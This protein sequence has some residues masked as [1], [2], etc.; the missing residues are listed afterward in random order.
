MRCSV[1]FLVGT[2]VTWDINRSKGGM[3]NKRNNYIERVRENGRKL[4]M[5]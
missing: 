4:E 2:T 3:E 1:E 5:A